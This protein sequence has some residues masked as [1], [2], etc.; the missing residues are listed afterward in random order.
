M[1]VLIG[2]DVGTSGLKAIALSTDGE[3]L[4]APR[5][6]TLCRRLGPAGLS[7]TLMIGGLLHVVRFA[8]SSTN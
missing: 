5:T 2:I 6:R 4:R 8:L 3:I 7:K 1:D